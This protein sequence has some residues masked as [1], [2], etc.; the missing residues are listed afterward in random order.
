M[1][2]GLK[3]DFFWGAFCGTT[4]VM[5]CYKAFANFL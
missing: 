4:E 3:P 1:W 2:Q 5:P